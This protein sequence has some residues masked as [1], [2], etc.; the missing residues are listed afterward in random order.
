[1]PR[2]RHFFLAFLIG[3]QTCGSGV[4][5]EENSNGAENMDP[6]QHIS[7]LRIS[8]ESHSYDGDEKCRAGIVTQTQETLTLSLG[9]L[10]FFIQTYYIAD[11]G[12]VS[13]KEA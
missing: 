4:A 10:A 3:I 12:R 8:E 7:Y 6:V 5:Y 9:K 2:E 1:M 11:T 13:P